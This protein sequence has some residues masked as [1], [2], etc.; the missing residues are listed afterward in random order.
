MRRKTYT[1]YHEAGHAVVGR[2]LGL[3]CG[4][5]TVVPDVVGYGCTT[6]K[7]PLATL[8]E[9]D[10]RGRSRF[11]GSD[12]R[13]IYRAYIMALM[14]GREAAELC[15]GIGGSF[16]G[17]GDDMQQIEN[18]VHG[19]Y[20]LDLSYLGLPRCDASGDF[21]R[22]D[23]LRKATRGLC[24]RHREKIERVAQTLIKDQSLSPNAIEALMRMP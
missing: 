5:A 23:R 8:D 6:I 12:L 24:I 21:D 16:V 19:S 18:L 17:D 15:C 22:V 4:S 13:S 14:A 2:V 20:H 3:L 10:A 9:W 7:S 1:A 11:N